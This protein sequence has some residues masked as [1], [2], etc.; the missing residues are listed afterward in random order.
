MKNLGRLENTIET[1]DI[2]TIS[3]A[4]I[5]TRYL[6][7]HSFILST[8]NSNCAIHVSAPVDCDIDEI[9]S[10]RAE[11]FGSIVIHTILLALSNAFTITSGEVAVYCDNSDALCKNNIVLSDISFPRLFRPNVDTKLQ[12]QTLRQQL[13]S[14]QILPIHIKGHQDDDD[15]F[16]YDKSTL[17]VKLNIE[18]DSQSKLYLKKHQGK[19]EPHHSTPSL[20]AMKSFLSINNSIIQNNLEHHVRMNYFRPKLETRFIAKSNLPHHAI[21]HIHWLAIERA[22]RELP[23]Q[24]KLATFNLLHGK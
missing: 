8:K 2:I 20:P 19:M 13:K 10:T 23:L 22:F 15:A 24:E 16:D 5:G 9:E 18:V 1:G 11:I 7:A 4:S 21:Q 12:I 14:I 3:D 17:S 6:A